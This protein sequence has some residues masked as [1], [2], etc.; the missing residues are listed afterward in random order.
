MRTITLENSYTPV[1]F[2]LTEDFGFFYVVDYGAIYS[3]E[4][5]KPYPVMFEAEHDDYNG[6]SVGFLASTYDTDVGTLFATSVNSQ[7]STGF[8]YMLNPYASDFSP[9]PIASIEMAFDTSFPP[10]YDFYNA[11]SVVSVIEDSGVFYATV[12]FSYED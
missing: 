5:W 12:C 2:H 8:L 6:A 11:D 1:G 3:V 9:T 4:A 7:Y 10:D